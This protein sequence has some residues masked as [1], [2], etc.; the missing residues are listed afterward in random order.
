MAIEIAPPAPPPSGPVLRPGDPALVTDW[1]TDSEASF[2][3]RVVEP[4]QMDAGTSTTRRTVSGGEVTIETTISVPMQQMEVTT[5]SR[6]DAATLAPRAHTSAGGPEAQALAF[7][8]TA[9]TGTKTPAEGEATGVDVALAAPVF[10]ASMMG[11]IAQSLPFADGYTATVEAYDTNLGVHAITY[12]V[13]G[14][15]EV[16]GAMAWT[17]EAASPA[18]PVTYVVEAATRR[19]VS[20]RMS[21]Q[22]GMVVEMGQP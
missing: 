3:I 8:P 13:T 17:V 20:M 21:P 9:V 10:D 4:M 2:V 1:M 15:S 5:V 14:Q 12:R 7:T 16:G 11:Q 18:G 19:L 6:A 22:P